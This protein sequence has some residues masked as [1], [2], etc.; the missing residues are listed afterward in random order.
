M[1]LYASFLAGSILT[2]VMPVTLLLIL[3]VWYWYTAKRIG[4]AARARRDAHRVVGGPGTEAPIG[5][6]GSEAQPPGGV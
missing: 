3:W 2:L 6:G 4:P 5:A 1:T